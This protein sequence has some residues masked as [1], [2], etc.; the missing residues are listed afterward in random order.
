APVPAPIFNPT[1]ESS[2]FLGVCFFSSLLLGSLLS[3]L[4]SEPL[5]SLFIFSSF[6]SEFYLNYLMRKLY[7]Y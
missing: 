6:F 1:L 4:S 3:L 7:L 5:L 2:L